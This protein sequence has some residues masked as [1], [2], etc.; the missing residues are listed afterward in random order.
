MNLME[1]CC[2]YKIGDTVSTKRQGTATQGRVQKM[3]GS[4]DLE[5]C[6]A[7]AFQREAAAAAHQRK[8]VAST[9]RLIK[10]QD[11]VST[12]KR[13][14]VRNITGVFLLSLLLRRFSLLLPLGWFDDWILGATTSI[15]YRQR[16][17]LTSKE[18]V[19]NN[20]SHLYSSYDN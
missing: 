15:V 3:W 8:M 4:E 19:R 6:V 7:A 13:K 16:W 12:R 9:S 2:Y 14:R 1:V 18:T 5:L 11:P 17:S 10:N 20:Y